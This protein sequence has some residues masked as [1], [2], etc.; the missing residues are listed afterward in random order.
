MPASAANI[1]A[2][3]RTC[4]R[5]GAGDDGVNCPTEGFTSGS[6][7]GGTIHTRPMTDCHGESLLPSAS[8]KRSGSTSIAQ[9]CGAW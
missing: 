6:S 3:P 7:L 5:Y 4:S 2:N 8:M 1:C 9:R